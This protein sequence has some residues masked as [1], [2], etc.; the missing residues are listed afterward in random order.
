MELEVNRIQITPIRISQI[1]RK[2]P[3][4]LKVLLSNPLL[5]TIGCKLN[6][7]KKED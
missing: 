3:Q 7:S 2:Q 4:K 6:K 5:L 1:K